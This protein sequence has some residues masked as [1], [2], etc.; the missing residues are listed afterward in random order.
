ML[1]NRGGFLKRVFLDICIIIFFSFDRMKWHKCTFLK[2]PLVRLGITDTNFANPL[3]YARLLSIIFVAGVAAR[4]GDGHP[5]Q[6]NST[7][8]HGWGEVRESGWVCPPQPLRQPLPHQRI[9]EGVG[10]LPRQLHQQPRWVIVACVLRFVLCKF[11]TNRVGK[12]Y[13]L[14]YVCIWNSTTLVNCKVTHILI[15]INQKNV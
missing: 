9:R 2:H 13:E 5:V 10:S 12:I 1:M 7:G 15:T 8:E 4:P 14:N 11:R 3:D 6:G